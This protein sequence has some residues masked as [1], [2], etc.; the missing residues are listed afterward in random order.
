MVV[1]PVAAAGDAQE[2]VDQEP[3]EVN[4]GTAGR[5][6]EMSQEQELKSEEEEKPEEKRNNLEYGGVSEDDGDASCPR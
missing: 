4:P 6:A 2:P 3:V 5:K 1:E